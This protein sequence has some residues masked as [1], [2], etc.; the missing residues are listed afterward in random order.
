MDLVSTLK[1]GGAVAVMAVAATY[2][3][4]R[5]VHVERSAVLPVAPYAVIAL[6]SSTE[7]YQAFNPYLTADPALKIEGFGPAAGI[8]SGFR[9]DGKDGTGTQTVAAV[10][11]G[12]VVYAIDLGALGRPTQRIRA[13]P[14]TNGTVV[15]WSVESDMGYNPVFRVFGLFMDRMMGPTFEQG[16]ANLRQAAA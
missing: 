13:T 8:G 5:T 16:L 3:L 10:T 6:A 1:I 11:E 9:F 7:G 12:E 4:P 15:T 2:M 14:V